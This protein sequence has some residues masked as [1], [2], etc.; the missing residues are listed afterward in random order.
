MWSITQK[1]SSYRPPE[2]SQYQFGENSYNPWFWW[3]S[4]YEPSNLPI[5]LNGNTDP[6]GAH[7]L[8]FLYFLIFKFFNFLN[9]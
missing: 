2:L 7:Q 5:N 8:I 4:N 6:N 3:R 9:I 1:N